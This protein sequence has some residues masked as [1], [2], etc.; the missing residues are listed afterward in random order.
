MVEKK[1][2][3]GEEKK[4]DVQVEYVYDSEFEKVKDQ[5]AELQSVF[6]RFQSI[7]NSKYEQVCIM[8][9]WWDEM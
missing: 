3:D 9:A 4:E 1:L 7:A 5:Y 8:T 2:Q 6:E